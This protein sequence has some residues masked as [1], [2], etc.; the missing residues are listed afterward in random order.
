MADIFDYRSRFL[1]A[2]LLFLLMLL[3]IPA[4]AETADMCAVEKITRAVTAS[5]D[6]SEFSQTCRNLILH[7]L[8]IPALVKKTKLTMEGVLNVSGLNIRSYTSQAG[9]KQTDT[10][11]DACALSIADNIQAE[12]LPLVEISYS[13]SNTL[14]LEIRG[15]LNQFFNKQELSS[16]SADDSYGYTLFVGPSFYAGSP[17]DTSRMYTQLGLGYNVIDA[18]GDIFSGNCPKSLGAGLSLGLKKDKS[19]IRIGYNHF[20][21]L[22]GESSHLGLHENLDVSSIFLFV[23]YNFDS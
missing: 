18:S 23:T 14:A 2:F 1:I 9:F 16:G 13:L 19:D 10:E 15:H 11:D 20:N 3:M 7:K 17:G 21:A 6:Y 12:I 22:S 4:R 5:Y 8:H